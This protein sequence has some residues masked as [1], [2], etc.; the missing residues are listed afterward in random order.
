MS[1]QTYEVGGPGSS[2]EAT[3]FRQARAGCSESLNRL[4]AQHDGLVQVRS[5]GD[6]GDDLAGR[7]L[8]HVS[9]FWLAL[10]P[11]SAVS[12]YWSKSILILLGFVYISLMD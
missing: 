4:M 6:L 3:L 5:V 9:S 12:V 10:P 7:F 2:S 11:R 1:T 8:G